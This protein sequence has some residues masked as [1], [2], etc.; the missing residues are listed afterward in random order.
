MLCRGKCLN[1]LLT[2]S[3]KCLNPL[4]TNRIRN[5]RINTSILS[6]MCNP[7][8]PDHQNMCLLFEYCYP[9]GW[10]LDSSECNG[11]QLDEER[12]YFQLQVKYTNPSTS[13]EHK[14]CNEVS[15]PQ[16]PVEHLHKHLH[17][18]NRISFIHYHW[19]EI[20]AYSEYR[21]SLDWS[22]DAIVASLL[23]S[24]YVV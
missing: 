20:C 1:P 8:H 19:I 21:Y 17:V 9:S 4:L 5:T 16:P 6:V 11:V 3:M 13:R 7:S 23:W 14:Q 15:D 2:N 18:V 10:E 22:H 12:T 24:C